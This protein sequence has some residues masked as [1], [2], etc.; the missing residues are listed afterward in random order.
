MRLEERFNSRVTDWMLIA[1]LR[2]L[3]RALV[4]LEI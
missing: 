4:L 1:D 3:L 2:N